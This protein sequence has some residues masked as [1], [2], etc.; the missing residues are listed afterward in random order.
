MFYSIRHITKFAY[1]ATV[2]E[3]MTEVRMQPRNESNQRC[4]KF[5]LATQPRA[6]IAAYRDY[7]GNAVH[8]F[9]IP[10]RH[11][12]LKIT[13]ESTVEVTAP[14]SLPDQMPFA[15]EAEAWAALDRSNESSEHWDYLQPSVFAFPTPALR[16]LQKELE[17]ERA[18]DPLHLLR[19]INTAIYHYFEYAQRATSVDS[20]IDVALENRKGVCQDFSHVMIALAR[21]L[22]IPCRYISG[23]LYHEK[24][25]DGGGDRSAADATHAWVETYLPEIGWVGFDPTNNLIVG[26]RHVRAAVGRDYADV[27]PTKG[28]FKGVASSE[29][30]VGVKVVTTDAPLPEEEL[31]PLTTWVNEFIRPSGDEEQQHQQQ[32]Q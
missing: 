17:I 23:Y 3:S 9:D 11:V 27:P 19:R 18:G 21:E 30:S 2:T 4:M 8:H 31:M 16:A 5:E 24:K 6:R 14:P 15:S 25:D 10:G 32:Q 22:R 20:P 12:R 13:A 29:L 26:E 1:S 28:V 7:Q